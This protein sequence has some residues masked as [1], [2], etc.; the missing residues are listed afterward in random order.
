[1][2]AVSPEH[3]GNDERHGG[4]VHLEADVREL[5]QAVVAGIED[6]GGVDAL[7][8]PL[9]RSSR[10]LGGPVVTPATRDHASAAIAALD[11]HPREPPIRSL[12]DVEPERSH[13][14]SLHPYRRP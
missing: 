1:V 12:D 8:Q 9:D 11:E 7:L 2:N 10:P 5:E 14:T 3:R 13:H 4:H 6:R